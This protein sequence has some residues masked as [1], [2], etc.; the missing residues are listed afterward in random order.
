MK[1]SWNE[2]WDRGSDETVVYGMFSDQREDLGS[3]DESLAQVLQ[4]VQEKHPA[5]SDAG[6]IHILMA[7]AGD[8]VIAGL[9]KKENWSVKKAERT[10]ASLYRFLAKEKVNSSLLL[11]DSFGG[12]VDCYA[13]FAAGLELGSYEVDTYKQ[14][15][16]RKAELHVKVFSES[17]KSIE[18][19][20]QSGL[21]QGKATNEARRLVNTPANFMTPS[22]LAE[23]ALRLG[24]EY[25]VE[26]DVYG[27]EEI[28]SMEMGALLAVA[29][30]SDEPPRFITMKYRGNPDSQEWDAAL[31]GKGL[32][33]DSGGYSL[34]TRD[35]MKTM[36]MDMGGAATV[37]GAMRIIM[38]E[39][40]SV[41][42]MAVIPSTE[43]LINGQALKPGDVITSMS[44][45]TIE[46][47]NTDAEGRLI[48]ADAVTYARQAGA[49]AIIDV[50]TLTGAAV[51]ALGSVMTA[52]ITND[53][54]LMS[55]VHD[56]SE[57]AG[58]R[59]WSLPNDEDYKDMVK[60]SDV[61][62]LNNSPGRQA[63]TITAGLFIGEFAEDTPWV[64][65]DIAG[66]AW[67]E[68]RTAVGPRGG[69][70]TMVRTIAE[71]VMN[72]GKR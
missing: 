33:Y 32:T 7:R 35:G 36:K 28:E 53:V 62:D 59:V 40:P 37:L 51:V 26:V 1:I 58:E 61:A 49:K 31:V 63:G 55:E 54:D 13:Q 10:G 42:V 22:I 67:Q 25:D 16:K 70:G 21:V 20:V 41:N 18:T 34:K 19:A 30:G 44:G 43:N 29:K 17:R 9:G 3:M 48:L 12:G 56:A 60:K 46:V 50:A 65:L 4:S 47:L 64:H 2:K 69:T 24:S 8:V 57:R 11:I 38:E 5:W 52:A 6:S 23:E 72:I 15:H 14:N 39:K 68:G 66:T 27:K 45:K 71:T